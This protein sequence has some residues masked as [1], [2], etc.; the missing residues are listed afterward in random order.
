MNSSFRIIPFILIVAMLAFSVRVGEVVSGFRA[1]SGSAIAADSPKEDAQKT[2]KDP[3]SSPPKTDH[4][5]AKTSGSDTVKS[6]TK[7]SDVPPKESTEKSTT[8]SWPNASD[9]DPELINVRD[10]LVKDL[11]AR[12]A[13]IET[14]EKNIATREA[15][16]KAG[17]DELDQ[18]FQELLELR[19]QLQGLL[20]QQSE[21]EAERL[22]SLV[23]IY[24]GMKPSDAARIFNTLDINVLLDVMTRMSERKSAP[25]LAAMEPDRARMVTIM[26][27]QQKKLPDLPALGG[28]DTKQ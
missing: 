14:Q 26:M 15:V 18:K 19:K 28:G 8:K 24:E 16:L 20:N 6:D 23:R 17:Q 1:L 10:G 3:A 2:E 21:E 13:V 9:I 5:G 12:R 11:A 22:K 27:A 25:I 4:P 7:I